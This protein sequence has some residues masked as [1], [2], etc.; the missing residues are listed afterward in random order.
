MGF[1]IKGFRFRVQ[2]VGC[3][4]LGIGETSYAYIGAFAGSSSLGPVHHSEIIIRLQII[5]RMIILRDVRSAPAST[6]TL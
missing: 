5:I 3:R 2:G 6:L 1:Q 4:N